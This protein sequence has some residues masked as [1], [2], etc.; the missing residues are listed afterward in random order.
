MPE[1]ARF[2][3]IVIRMYCEAGEPHNQPHFH[4]YNQDQAGVFAIRPVRLIAGSLPAPQRRLVETWARLHG[5][6]LQ[7]DW[8][9]LLSGDRP[10]PIQPLI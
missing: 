1:L 8:E 3:G 2:Y 5:D 4:A 10:R 9:L 6:E 7:R